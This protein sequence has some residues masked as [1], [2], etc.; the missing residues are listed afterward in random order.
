[1]EVIGKTGATGNANKMTTISKG[2]HLHFEAR[3]AP[4][5]GVGLDGRFD[6]IPFINANLPY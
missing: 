3:S 2:A 5:L 4:L 1:G 6:P